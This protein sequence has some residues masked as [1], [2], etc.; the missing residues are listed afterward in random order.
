[1]PRTIAGIPEE[2][3]LL[4]GATPKTQWSAGNTATFHLVVR[5]RLRSIG[6]IVNH[7]DFALH[8]LVSDNVTVSG[9][10]S[11]QDGKSDVVNYAIEFEMFGNEVLREIMSPT[12]I[13]LASSIT[14]AFLLIVI[15]LGN[16]NSKKD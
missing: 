2:L 9:T 4:P 1:M 13:V 3:S 16:R 5:K 14:I 6:I 10:G 8:F 7:K 12:F 15:I 11:D